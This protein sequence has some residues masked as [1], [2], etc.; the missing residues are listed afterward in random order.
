MLATPLTL[1][2]LMTNINLGNAVGD[3]LF[4]DSPATAARVMANRAVV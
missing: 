2:Q 4:E 1:Q 3:V